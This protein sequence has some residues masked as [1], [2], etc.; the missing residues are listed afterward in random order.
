MTIKADPVLL[1]VKDESALDVVTSERGRFVDVEE[2]VV[3]VVGRLT[4]VLM[5]KGILLLSPL[6]TFF[7]TIFMNSVVSLS[8][9]LL[10]GLGETV[11]TKRILAS[12]PF[13]FPSS[14]FSLVTSS[15]TEVLIKG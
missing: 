13:F 1:P 4:I 14:A 9:F 10:N 11:E 3:V 6:A 15:L 5:V 12:L 8:F 7:F 2:E